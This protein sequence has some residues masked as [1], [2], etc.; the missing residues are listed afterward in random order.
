MRKII[1]LIKTPG[2]FFRDYLNKKYPIIRN[3]IACPLY[4]EKVL[5]KHDMFLENK[6]PT[7]F[8]IDVVYTWVD[9]NDKKWQEKFNN[10]NLNN[11]VEVGRHAT[12]KARFDNH[13]EIY[14]SIKSVL[15][16]MPWV[17]NIFIVTDNQVPDVLFLSSK[18]K[19]VDHQDIIDNTFLPTFNSHVIEAHL[20]NIRDLSEHFIYFNDDVFVARPLM[21]SHFFRSNGIAS[22]FLSAKDLNELKKRG[23]DTPTLS[24]S[25]SSRAL[26]N[27]DYDVSIG[28]PFV[29]T[30]I[31]LRKTIF[32]MAWE[33]YADEIIK[34]LDNRFRTNNDLN[35]ATFLVPWLA[36][37]KGQ[38]VPARD[39]CYYFNIRSNAATDNYRTLGSA[40]INEAQPHSFC[41]NDFHTEREAIKNY[42]GLLIT[43]LDNYFKE[44]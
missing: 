17:R 3:E 37:I 27:S 4:D 41:A 29:H 42:K 6:L 36:Y 10:F 11:S 25:I 7:E 34:F 33:Y 21:A 18:I 9:N 31:P 12:D 22:I 20:H 16:N 8:P 38:A 32:C 44:S 15:I 35:L 23:V 39:I 40:L 14:Y 24:A 19:V 26:L 2:L 13:N 43:A 1:K 30:Y 28:G 5:I